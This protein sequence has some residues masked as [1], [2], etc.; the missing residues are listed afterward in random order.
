MQIGNHVVEGPKVDEKVM[1]KCVSM[2]FPL[3]R[4]KKAVSAQMFSALQ[5]L[6]PLLDVSR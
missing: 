1:L 5:Q 4:S 3:H 6:H 2:L